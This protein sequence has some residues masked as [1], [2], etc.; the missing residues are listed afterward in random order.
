MRHSWEATKKTFASHSDND[1]TMA[2]HRAIHYKSKVDRKEYLIIAKLSTMAIESLYPDQLKILKY[3]IAAN[4]YQCFS[5]IKDKRIRS[6]M[7]YFINTKSNELN[8]F[9]TVRS[10]TQIYNQ[11]ICDLSTAKWKV[12]TPLC[13]EKKLKH[14]H[15]IMPNIHCL[16]NQIHMLYHRNKVTYHKKFDY[17]TNDFIKLKTGAKAIIP[18][19]VL[20]TDIVSPLA[21][22]LKR[23]EQFV[24]IDIVTAKVWGLDINKTGSKWE[25]ITNRA[26]GNIRLPE[27]LYKNSFSILNEAGIVSG[28][29]Q[30]IYLFCN[31][32]TCKSDSCWDWRRGYGVEQCIRV[33]CL[34][35]VDKEWHESIEE[36][37]QK[38]RISQR[39]F[40]STGD[41]FCYYYDGDENIKLDLWHISPNALQIVIQ[42]R[43]EMMVH[44]FC[45][46]IEKKYCLN[47]PVYLKRIVYK[48]YN[49]L[50]CS[51]TYKYR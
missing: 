28:F 33:F 41:R 35:F 8:V 30:I 21:V 25:R 16:N 39:N 19:A 29:G 44:G 37:P 46:G 1:I 42:H 14:F 51:I 50:K 24:L 10:N 32:T 48:Y 34:D 49:D 9:A 15:V 23:L 31:V 36:L 6:L 11:F 20:G 5:K 22:Y 45:G 26:G 17:A 38:M 12:I 27:M 47:F 2:N 13:S 7:G 40:V 4:K 18:D 43:L 3:D